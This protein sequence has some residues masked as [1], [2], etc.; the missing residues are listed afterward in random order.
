MALLSITQLADLAQLAI[1]DPSAGTWPQ[2]TVE[3]WAIEAI[4][5][6]E[7]AFPRSLITT[8]SAANGIHR[9]ALPMGL[10]AILSVEYPTGQTPPKY[11]VQYDRRLPS[12]W[13]AG[14]Q[15]YDVENFRDAGSSSY[16]WISPTP[17]PTP[18][19]IEVYYQAEQYDYLGNPMPTAVTAPDHHVP[20]LVQ[21][22]VW[23]AAQE[24]MFQEMLA[25]APPGGQ[26]EQSDTRYSRMNAMAI[27]VSNARAVYDNALTNAK[28][29]DTDAYPVAP[30]NLTT[31]AKAI[32]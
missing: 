3:A 19:T 10:R 20:L 9:Y 5:D 4:R 18:G 11:L 8:L 21:Y 2:A 27:I 13:T 32:S 1:C 31:P 15:F 16:L 22:I 26:Y 29:Q 24:H 25:P 30:W 17:G 6:Y 12:F 7:A 23:K 14:V 28:A